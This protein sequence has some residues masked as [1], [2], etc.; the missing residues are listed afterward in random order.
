MSI[1]NSLLKFLQKEITLSVTLEK[2]KNSILGQIKMQCSY[3][4]NIIKSSYLSLNM[5][6]HLYLES[7][8]GT[9]H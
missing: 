4:V 1:S 8:L 2:I 6:I 5:K 3:T 9:S 7:V